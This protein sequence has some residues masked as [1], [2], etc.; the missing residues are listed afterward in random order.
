M[1][2]DP[3]VLHIDSRAKYA[4]AFFRISFS[5]LSLAF[6]WRNRLT[7]AC[8][9]VTGCAGVR[10]TIASPLRAW[11]TQFAS[12]LLDISSERATDA[13]GRPPSV[14]ADLNL[15]HLG[16]IRAVG[17]GC[18]T[19]GLILMVGG[20]GHVGEGAGGGQCRR[21]VDGQCRC[22]RSH[23]PHVHGLVRHVAAAFFAKLPARRLSLSRRS[24]DAT[25]WN[26]GSLPEILC[27]A[28]ARHVGKSSTGTILAAKR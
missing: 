16:G 9:S 13:I 2:F 4:A 19:F 7:S 25:K 17:A 3:S 23:R 5:N 27:A 14:N 18:V 20:G 21:V 15:T 8:N 6:S 11:Y 1:L 12:D 10:L 22:A 28:D 26:R 24:L